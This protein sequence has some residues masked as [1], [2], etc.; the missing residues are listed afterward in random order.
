MSRHQFMLDE[1]IGIIGRL[2]NCEKKPRD[3]EKIRYLIVNHFNHM[4]EPGYVNNY[5]SNHAT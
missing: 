4:N 3:R 2:E 1:K 5:V